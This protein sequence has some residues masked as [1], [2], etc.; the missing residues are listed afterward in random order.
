MKEEPNIKFIINSLP[1]EQNISNIH[2]DFKEKTEI[3][4]I[5]SNNNSLK[6]NERNLN[7]LFESKSLTSSVPSNIELTPDNTS[8]NEIQYNIN[9]LKEKSPNINNENK[10]NNNL[11]N[12][13]DSLKQNTFKIFNLK[14]LVYHKKSVSNFT[15]INNKNKLK[16]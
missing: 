16:K 10:N 6:I 1:N 4:E 8:I 14:Q 5:P 13:K 7:N 11:L 3:K 9:H 2:N 12:S 15:N